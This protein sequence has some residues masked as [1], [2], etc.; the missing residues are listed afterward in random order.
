MTNTPNTTPESAK[1]FAPQS[2][3]HII[4]RALLTQGDKVVIC[5]GKDRAHGYLPGGHVE[6]GE[7]AIVAL[8]REF[9]EEIGEFEH[10]EPEYIGTCENLWDYDPTQKQHELNVVFAVEI[11][12]GVEVASK[13]AHISFKSFD[14]NE[15]AAVTI[16]PVALK[17][18]IIK[19]M[20]DKKPFYIS[21]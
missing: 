1:Y 4:A 2:S 16:Y 9:I 18:A 13:E 7:S 8:K 12:E 3:I 17:E 10:S 5:V 14:K 11:A 15:L 21:M 19:W 20:D 6:N